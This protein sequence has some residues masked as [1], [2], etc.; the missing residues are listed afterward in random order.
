MGAEENVVVTRC[1]HNFH[2]RCLLRAKERTAACPLCRGLLTPVGIDSY[3]A[4]SVEAVMYN[5]FLC[6]VS[7]LTPVIYFEMSIPVISRQEEDEMVITTIEG[8][9]DLPREE[10]YAPE[11][12]YR[13]DIIATSRRVR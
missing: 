1:G 12:P 2:E 13:E 9:F 3:V 10:S 6:L 7:T 8:R 4:V 5:D 11:N